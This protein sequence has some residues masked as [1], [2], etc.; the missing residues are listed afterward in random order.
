MINKISYLIIKNKWILTG[1]LI[2][3][4]I[5]A[6]FLLQSPISNITKSPEPLIP[7]SYPNLQPTIYT[8]NLPKNILEFNWNNTLIE[9]PKAANKYTITKPLVNRDTISQLSIS[10]GFTSSDLIKTRRETSQTWQNSRSSL[11]TSLD[12]N[13]IIYSKNNSVLNTNITISGTEAV[14][15]SKAALSQLIGENFLGTLDANPKVRFLKFDPKIYGPVQVSDATKA[16]FI[17]VSF[18]QIIGTN[19]LSSLSGNTSIVTI[20]IDNQKDLHRLE[21]YGGYLDIVVHEEQTL[22]DVSTLKSIAQENALKISSL[23][24]ISQE[25]AYFDSSNI[26]VTVEQTYFGYFLTN[27]NSVIPVIFISGTAKSE[28]LTPETVVFVVPLIKN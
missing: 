12:Q 17:E 7:G 24:T 1:V 20:V 26:N 19:P 10:L 4:L 22:I 28:I 8:T 2:L 27:D 3:V 18:K 15:I 13:Q 6:L 23:S 16:E 25:G 11:F 5:I 14:S 9:I 21:I